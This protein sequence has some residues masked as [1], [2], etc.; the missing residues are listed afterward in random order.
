MGPTVTGLSG[1]F[2]PPPQPTAAS[3]AAKTTSRKPILIPV[4]TPRAPAG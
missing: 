2:V 3:T 4:P 1:Y